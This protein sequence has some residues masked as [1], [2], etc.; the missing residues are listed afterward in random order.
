MMAM[1]G[2][3]HKQQNYVLVV[4][5]YVLMLHLPVIPVPITL[6][7]FLTDGAFV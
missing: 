3:L 5:C 4:T 7:G 1:I 2:Y 6:Q